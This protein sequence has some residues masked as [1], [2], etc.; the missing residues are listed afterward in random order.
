[1]NYSRGDI[2]QRMAQSIT[3]PRM[4]DKGM[5]GAINSTRKEQQSTNAL[6]QALVNNTR[7]RR[8]NPRYN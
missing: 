8:T 2:G 3:L 1:V 7:P 4:F 6:L 5:V